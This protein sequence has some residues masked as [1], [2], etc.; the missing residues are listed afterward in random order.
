MRYLVL[1][2]L[3]LSLIHSTRAHARTFTRCQL[4]RELLRYNFPRTLIP[5]CKYWI[6]CINEANM[7]HSAYSREDNGKLLLR[8]SVPHTRQKSNPH[9]RGFNIYSEKLFFS[10]F[11]FLRS[12][13]N[14]MRGIELRDSTHNQL[15]IRRK[16][17]KRKKYLNGNRPACLYYV[18]NKV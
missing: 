2:W 18:E 5:N 15:K 10:I 8:H 1:I 7:L 16:K 12:G 9:G 17:K 13:N 3:A 14:T 11:L 6:F 4:S